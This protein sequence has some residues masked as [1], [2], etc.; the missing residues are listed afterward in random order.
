MAL[1]VCFCAC[2][3]G[4]TV[5]GGHN[6]ARQRHPR[7]LCEVI[8]R[9]PLL[10]PLRPNAAS[11]APPPA[12]LAAWAHPR[13]APNHPASPLRRI[14]VG[15]LCCS[16]LDQPAGPAASWQCRPPRSV[17]HRPAPAGD[18]P[19]PALYTA[20]ERRQRERLVAR[21]PRSP[22]WH[23]QPR[24]QHSHLL[25]PRICR[26]AASAAAPT[27]ARRSLWWAAA[28]LGLAQ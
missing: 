5:Q 16:S 25:P 12:S 14:A 7:I 10:S 28:G 4:Q 1:P 8:R 23:Q 26:A 3:A 21:G 18:R 20:T 9:P 2:G 27:T 13:S 17:L 15:G 11:T 19:V 22:P 6:A 24:R